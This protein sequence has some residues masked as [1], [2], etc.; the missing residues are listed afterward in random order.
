M[1]ERDDSSDGE[2]LELSQEDQAR[3]V[4]G[5][6]PGH[7]RGAGLQNTALGEILLA[8]SEGKANNSWLISSPLMHL[9]TPT[10]TSKPYA[11]QARE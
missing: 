6:T 11:A 8:L 2:S 7:T 10:V 5:A 4:I 9:A 1:S 3:D